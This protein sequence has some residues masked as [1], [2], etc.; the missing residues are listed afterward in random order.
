VLAV[1][2]T[3]DEHAQ[4]GTGAAPGLLG[5]LQGKPIKG[6]D[7]IPRDHALGFDAQD[8]VEIGADQGDE[9]RG[10]ISGRAAELGVEGASA[11]GVA[12]T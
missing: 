4:A 1:E 5:H 7:V 3:P 6:D 12:D 8:L 11:A 10:G 9:R 2:M